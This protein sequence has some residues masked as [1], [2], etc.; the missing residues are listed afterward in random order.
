[1]YVHD[2][3]NLL[4]PIKLSTSNF[5]MIALLHKADTS[6]IVPNMIVK[7]TALK[8]EVHC[9]SDLTHLEFYFDAIKCRMCNGDP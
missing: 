7:N 2:F 6:K 3:I 4:K 8:F 1:M 9:Y 5:S